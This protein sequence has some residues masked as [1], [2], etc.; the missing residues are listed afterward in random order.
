MTLSK[1]ALTLRLAALCLGTAVAAS[2]ALAQSAAP[3]AAPAAPAAAPAVAA[4]PP[5]AQAPAAALSPA[6]L[7]AALEVV[8]LS[9]MSKSIDLVV[10]E[11]VDKARALF[12]QM[13]PE[14]AA[15][16]DKSIKTLQPQFD[17]QQ[18]EAQKIVARAF[19]SR[20]SEADLKDIATFFKTPAGQKFVSSQPGILDEM[21]RDMEPFSQRL[22]QFVVDK[23]REDMKSRGVQF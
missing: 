17:G 9:G 10:P 2:A 12:T 11:M 22:S 20:L 6:H 3:A 8:K 18:V 16:I 7:E 5:V 14:L 21:F 13:R 4:P 1:S 15:E 23:L 19:G